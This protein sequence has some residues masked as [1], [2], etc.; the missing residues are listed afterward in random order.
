MIRWS[1]L[2]PRLGVAVVVGGVVLF[3]T[4]P[5]LRSFVCSS[6]RHGLGVDAQVERVR[7]DAAAG[8]FVAENVRLASPSSDD[9][10]FVIPKATLDI[11]ASSLTRRRFVVDEVSATGVEASADEILA[12]IGRTRIDLA[13]PPFAARDLAEALASVELDVATLLRE[14]ATYVTGE[15]IVKEWETRLEL[16]K[17]R[18]K[19]LEARVSLLEKESAE[20]RT[21]PLRAVDRLATIAKELESVRVES[22]TLVKELKGLPNQIEADRLRLREAKNADLAKLRAIPEVIKAEPRQIAESLIG[23]DRLET[24]KLAYRWALAIRELASPELE[25]ERAEGRNVFF[26]SLSGEPDLLVRRFACDGTM[27]SG[28]DRYPFALVCTNWT[29]QPRRMTEPLVVDFYVERP[30]PTRVQAVIDRTTDRP[31][32]TLLVEVRSTQPVRFELGKETAWALAASARQVVCT[33]HA[34]V[35]DDRIEGAAVLRHQGVALDPVGEDSQ[36]SELVAAIGEAVATI[37]AFD[38]AIRFE[39][40][41][42]APKFQFATDLADRLAPAFEKVATERLAR[43]RVQLES[44]LAGSFDAIEQRVLER[45]KQ[46]NGE[47]AALAPKL[48]SLAELERTVVER[49]SPNLSLPREALKLPNLLRR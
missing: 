41:R 28:D 17:R 38:V 33:V 40:N 45:V 14:S 42:E 37:D 21:N 8:A 35:V 13:P 25:P 27:Q 12:S 20:L 34:E 26:P 11:D 5:A 1:Y 47:F 6:L 43:R 18:A 7:F 31:R 46:R 24:A 39:G 4:G 22:N 49:I 23:E 32:D 10:V 44:Q 15:Q 30:L 3:G 29:P 19:L 48:P 9:A 36:R 16:L 2:L